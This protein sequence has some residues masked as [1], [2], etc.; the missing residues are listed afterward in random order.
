[1]GI[2]P[3]Q[4]DD[5]LG[6][7]YSFS[8]LLPPSLV[9]LG[10]WQ[11]FVKNGKLA[12]FFC[13]TDEG[14]T[15]SGV[16]LELKGQEYQSTFFRARAVFLWLSGHSFPPIDSKRADNTKLYIFAAVAAASM[17]LRAPGY[18]ICWDQFLSE[19][20]VRSESRRPGQ[21][22]RPWPVLQLTRLDP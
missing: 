12:M 2:W 16:L 13:L 20:T 4:D 21:P 19:F 7:S 15:P 22:R 9:V 8:G 11:G 5:D 6:R 10:A 1:M 17:E 14:P 3:E 18:T